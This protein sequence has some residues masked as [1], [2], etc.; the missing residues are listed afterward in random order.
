MSKVGP[1]KLAAVCYDHIGGALG[2]SLY[3]ALV[4]KAWVSADGGGLKVTPKGRREIG[5]AGSPGRRARFQR[6]QAGQRLRGASRRHVLCPHRLSTRLAAGRGAG[7]AG[8]AGKVGPRVP[9]HARGPA[10]VP[11]A[12]R[13]V[14][15]HADEF[16]PSDSSPPIELAGRAAPADWRG[17]RL[18]G[19]AQTLHLL[20]DESEGRSNEQR[21]TSRPCPELVVMRRASSPQAPSLRL[22]RS[23]SSA[24][25]RLSHAAMNFSDPTLGH[26]PTARR[27]DAPKPDTRQIA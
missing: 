5:L 25:I 14:R 20:S 4:R 6:T 19:R 15:L 22:R 9:H 26:V 16:S 1:R 12:R 10:R 11:Q 17:P 2:E 13:Q 8:L 24:P 23:A 7:R 21:K 27:E 18:R 3:D